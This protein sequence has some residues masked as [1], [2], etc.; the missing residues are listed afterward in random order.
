MPYW[1][2]SIQLHSFADTTVG[3][4]QGTSSAG[5]GAVRRREGRFNSSATP[6][7]SAVSSDT[8]RTVN[9]S[10]LPT[11]CHQSGLDSRP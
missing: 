1:S 3:I 10:V 4:A 2:C 9:T 6:S 5:L 7:P 11:A 8:D